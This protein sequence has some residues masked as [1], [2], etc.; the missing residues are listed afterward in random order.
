MWQPLCK[1]GNWGF[2]Y[3]VMTLAPAPSPTALGSSQAAFFR[4]CASPSVSFLPREV[5]F[6]LL[7]VFAFCSFLR[8][9]API[10]ASRL[11]RP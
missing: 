8:S 4:L 7:P 5:F 1:Q 3:T 9:P 2:P 10:S 6:V 11:P